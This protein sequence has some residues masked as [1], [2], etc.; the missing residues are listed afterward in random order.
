MD[1]KPLFTTMILWLILSSVLLDYTEG[2]LFKES[3]T[4][5]S[6]R[7]RTKHQ[8]RKKRTN[9]ETQ[10]KTKQQIQKDA[11][12]RKMAISV[13]NSWVRNR[14]AEVFLVQSIFLSFLILVSVKM[15]F[16]RG[17]VTPFAIF[18]KKLERVFSSVEFHNDTAL[19]LNTILWHWDWLFPA[20][21]CCGWQGYT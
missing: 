21:C 2:F 12:L 13:L 10:K 20:A 4:R 11:S 17:Y 6:R 19:L 5:A 18:F 1:S 14:Y 15:G 3:T 8:Q 9:R 7:K 16:L